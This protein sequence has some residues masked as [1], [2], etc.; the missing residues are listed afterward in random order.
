M[1]SLFDINENYVF[2]IN[3]LE[4][5]IANSD[6]EVDIEVEGEAVIKA[7]EI[8]K[9]Q[10]ADKVEAYYYY[11]TQKKGDNQLIDDEIQRLQLRKQTNDN[12]VKRLKKYVNTA[13]ILF[14]E[15]G[16]TGNYKMKTNK[17]SVWNV[18]HKPLIVIDDFFVAK[19]MKY[20]LKKSFT[21]IEIVEIQE[22]LKTKGI[23]VELDSDINRTK[24]KQDLEAGVKIDQAYIDTQASYVRF[25]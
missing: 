6:G 1:A 24:L 15:Q 11:I 21:D 7:L 23:E 8:T 4:D 17:L 19:Y 16:K 25:K 12:I 18:F 2:L 14:G 3:Q 22:W 10:A 13:L 20:K 9:E 5:I